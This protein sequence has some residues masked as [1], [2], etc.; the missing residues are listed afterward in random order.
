MEIFK[1]LF[2][3]SNIFF[4]I[5]HLNYMKSFKFT[6]NNSLKPP[7]ELFTKTRRSPSYLSMV[8]PSR[9]WLTSHFE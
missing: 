9:T 3:R 7:A 8:A 2:I 4:D 6:K 1:L 5:L